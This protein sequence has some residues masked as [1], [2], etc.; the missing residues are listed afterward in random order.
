[1]GRVVARAACLLAAVF[2]GGCANTYDC[3][4]ACELMRDCGHLIGPAIETCEV[5][6]VDREADKEDAIDECG[7]CLDSDDCAVG[8]VDACVCA[9]SLDP[10]DYGGAVCSP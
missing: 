3:D 4:E 5:L 9:L 7:D 2:V 6:C 1:M 8:C 10:A